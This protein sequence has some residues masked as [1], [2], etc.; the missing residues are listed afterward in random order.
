MKAIT[1]KKADEI[2]RKNGMETWA[3]DGCRTFWATNENES[4]TWAFDS[5]KERDQ[6]VAKHNK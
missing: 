1:V 3:E 4:E 2:N 5:K 6:F